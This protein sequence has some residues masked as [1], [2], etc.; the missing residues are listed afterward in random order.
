MLAFLFR[1]FFRRGPRSRPVA[2]RRTRRSFVPRCEPLEGRNLLSTGLLG[3]Y[4][5]SPD[6]TGLAFSRVDPT[7]NFDFSTNPPVSPFSPGGYSVRW[8]GQVQPLYSE[9]YTF[10]SQVDDGGRLFVNGQLLF[11]HFTDHEPLTE[12]SGTITLEAG[13]KYDI[14]MDYFEDGTGSA[15]A[16]LLW[17]SASQAKGVIPESQLNT[18]PAPSSLAGFVFDD[19]NDNG[20]R[21]PSA[22]SV[23]GVTVT[24]TGTDESAAAVERTTTT[25]SDGSFVFL[26]LRPG[27]YRLSRGALPGTLLDGHTTAGLVGG[28]VNGTGASPA[29]TAVDDIVLGDGQDGSGYGFGTLRP[30]SLSGFVF[31]DVAGDGVRRPGAAGVSGVTL[32]LTGTDDLGR[33]VSETAVSGGD[34]SFSFAGLRPGSYRLERGPLAELLDGRSTAGLVGGAVDGTVALPAATAVDDIV[35]SEGQDGSDY[36]FGTLRPASLSGFVFDDVA[37]DGVRRPGAAGVPGVALTLTGT[38]DLGRAVSE[39]TVSG[40]DGSFNFAGLRPGLYRL[41][42]GALPGTLLDGHSTAGLV[43]GAVDGTVA[44]PAA[45]A[46]DG[47]VLGEGQDGNDY[48]FGTLRPASLSG[49]VFDDV[50]GDGVRRLGATG[51]PGI[52]LTLTGTDD[53]GQAVRL[54][55]TTAPDGAYHFTGLRP[56]TYTVDDKLGRATLVVLGDGVDAVGVDFPRFDLRSTAPAPT[57]AAPAP[58]PGSSPPAPTLLVL[59]PTPR[60]PPAPAPVPAP[61]PGATPSPSPS[62]PPLPVFDVRDVAIVILAVQGTTSSAKGEQSVTPVGPASVA[63][64]QPTAA[65]LSGGAGGVLLQGPEDRATGAEGGAL[66]AAASSGFRGAVRG[67]QVRLAGLISGAHEEEEEEEEQRQRARRNAALD[68][69][70]RESE[71]EPPPFKY[72]D[73][74]AGLLGGSSARPARRSREDP[75]L[76][77][78]RFFLGVAWLV[79]T[80]A[81]S[82]PPAFDASRSG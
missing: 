1:R 23:P 28:S 73:V 68:E 18:P 15:I 12:W 33:A 43:G 50:V 63:L 55:A 22:A 37:G 56:G 25:A 60:L 17:S 30:A 72:T 24:L 80:L 41:T 38:D 31:D 10:Y 77:E 9:T 36:G 21:A 13:R 14:E 51:A 52:T 59:S 6:L 45:T 4:F 61:T 67:Q 2:G 29:A 44:S 40:E 11:D 66:P 39:T 82:L 58:T 54:S 81:A 64:Q 62:A 46:V 8:T 71:D 75:F 3:E 49:F 48:G 70:L 78:Q 7:V 74:F 19:V 57:P 20:V 26:G 34:G 47:I 65:A 5:T 16:S 79:L 32:T 69:A 42:R 53:R 27:L 35:L 76:E